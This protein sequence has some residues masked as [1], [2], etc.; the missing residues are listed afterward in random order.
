MAVSLIWLLVLTTDVQPLMCVAGLKSS[1]VLYWRNLSACDTKCLNCSTTHY[2][3]TIYQL[4]IFL[5]L[6]VQLNSYASNV[7]IF[8]PLSNACRNIAYNPFVRSRI[9]CLWKADL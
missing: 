2:S 8:V 3:K 4:Q 5:K 1:M 7:L 6:S 9:Q